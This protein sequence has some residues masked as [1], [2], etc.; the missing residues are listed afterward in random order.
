[1]TTQEH[2]EWLLY[3]QAENPEGW[4]LHCR[5]R[6]RDL[7]K[8]PEH[9]QLPQMLDDALKAAAPASTSPGP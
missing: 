5:R 4:R 2:L 7:A 8:D 3:L 1:M 6:A 9:A